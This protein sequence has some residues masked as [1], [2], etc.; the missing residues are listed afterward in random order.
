[1]QKPLDTNLSANLPENWQ[2]EDTVS[3]SG[4][5]VGLSEQHGYNYLNKSVNDAQKA[6]NAINEAFDSVQEDIR[7]AE[8]VTSLAD[9]DT[10]SVVQA[11]S[12]AAKKITFAN[13]ITA[14]RTKLSNFFAAIVHSHGNISNDGKIG[15]TGNQV[16][17]TGS[18]GT[19]RAGTA[20]IAGGGTGATTA[21][22]ARAN[23]EI[24]PTNI[25]AA[26]TSHNHDA[27][28]INSGTLASDR[29]PTVPVAKGGTGVTDLNVNKLQ[30]GNNTD[31][32]WVIYLSPSG[33]DSSTGFSESAAMKSIRAAV[34]RYGG[35][36]RLQLI[37]AP[38]TYTDAG[39]LTITGNTYINISGAS[40]T[41]GSVV[42]A[43]PIIFQSTTVKLFQVTFDLSAS[44]ET[45]PGV[46]LRQSKYDI[47][48][49]VFKGKAAVHAGINAS[50]G[51]AGYI[52]NC[53]FQAGI[54][55]V[56]IG[57]G[58]SMT[59]LTCT[60]A[61]GFEIGFNVNG[62]TLVSNGNT[63]NATTQFTMYNSAV[64][65][66]DGAMLNPLATP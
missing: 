49:C 15:S 1:M 7:N 13:I 24:T 35:L 6:I 39:T 18:D 12:N 25:G 10:V 17:I 27:S 26:P 16:V 52:V 34:A 11:S 65:F 50:L 5:D 45:Y 3:P 36:S 28:N 60:V 19:L 58:A 64:I 63:N 38:G 41:P 33:N 48:N 40:A 47:Q 9:T 37:L 46:T 61:A 29:L 4:T 42:I 55:G 30:R 32:S 54:R 8:A 51:S 57:S 56:E 2:L 66:R 44:S 31:P 20:P 21:A 23:L 53:V 59:A 22:G 62:G 14:I 43:H